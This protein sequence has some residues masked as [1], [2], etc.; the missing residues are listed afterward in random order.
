MIE[1]IATKEDI[2]KLELLLDEDLIGI[3]SEWR[4]VLTLLH[5]PEPSIF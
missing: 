5:D 4:P 3:D 2:P 1:W